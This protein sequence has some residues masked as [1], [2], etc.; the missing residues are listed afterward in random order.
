MLVLMTSMNRIHLFRNSCFRQGY[1]DSNIIIAASDITR[2]TDAIAEMPV[3]LFQV[4]KGL[5]DDKQ[6]PCKWKESGRLQQH[7]EF[8]G[9]NLLD[10]FV[11]KVAI[12][13]EH[14]QPGCEP[15]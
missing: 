14:G 8:L 15:T 5:A 13:E 1:Q 10:G 6:K 11:S 9:R 3:S 12:K 7:T 4:H 2:T